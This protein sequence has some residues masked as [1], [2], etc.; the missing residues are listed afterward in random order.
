MNKIKNI[1]LLVS[2]I[3]SAI[4][5]T[6]NFITTSQVCAFLYNIHNPNVINIDCMNIIF[7]TAMIFF[8][9]P[10]VFLFSLI[11]YFLKDEIFK[12][13]SKFTYVWIPISIILT[14]ITPSSSGSFFVSLWD[15]QMTALFMSSLYVII[16]LAVV[17]FKVVTGNKK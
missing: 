6:V 13:W 8:I 15:Q 1:V 9:F 16:S 17:I 14:L 5:I 2:G 7:N 10:F 4:L 11:T 3:I 12:T